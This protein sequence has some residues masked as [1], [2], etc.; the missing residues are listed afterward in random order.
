M[1]ST[2]I[3]EMRRKLN[4]HQEK[5]GVKK[6]K[7]E[8]KK[9]HLVNIISNVSYLT[10]RKVADIAVAIDSNIEKV[11]GSIDNSISEIAEKRRQEDQIAAGLLGAVKPEHKV[12]LINPEAEEIFSNIMMSAEVSDKV[13]GQK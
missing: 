2:D 7:K 4:E 12:E 13:R 9:G 10:N 6:E 5:F 3:A 11:V 8:K 1:N